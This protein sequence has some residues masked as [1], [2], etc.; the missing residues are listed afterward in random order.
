MSNKIKKDERVE[1]SKFN[2]VFRREGVSPLDLDLVDSDMTETANTI[3]IF[4]LLALK[5][6]F[7]TLK[8]LCVRTEEEMLAIKGVS[9]RT[10]EY[11]RKKLKSVGLNFRPQQFTKKEWIARLKEEIKEAEMQNQNSEDVLGL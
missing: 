2:N 9:E 3:R 7:K 10:V 5:N 11:L 6:N 4:N 1:F 8:D